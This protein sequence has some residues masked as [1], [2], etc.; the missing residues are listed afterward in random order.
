MTN[1]YNQSHTMQTV[2]KLFPGIFWVGNSVQKR[3]TV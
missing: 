2:N 3:E 1:F